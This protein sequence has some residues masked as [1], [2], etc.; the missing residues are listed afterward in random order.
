MVGTMARYPLP[1]MLPL[2]VILLVYPLEIVRVGLATEVISE[3]FKE[4]MEAEGGLELPIEDLDARY[5]IAY[6][7]SFDRGCI[8]DPREAEED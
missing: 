3:L 8:R 7:L 5:V 1:L 6:K 4:V 2:L